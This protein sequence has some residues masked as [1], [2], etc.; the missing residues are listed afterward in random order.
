MSF[1]PNEKESTYL[2]R[3]AALQFAGSKEN[4]GTRHPIHFLQELSSEYEK[5]EHSDFDEN[6]D[7]IAMVEYYNCGDYETYDSVDELICSELCIDPDNKE[8][9]EK[10]N[11]KAQENNEIQFVSYSQASETNEIPGSDETIYDID[12]YLEAYG[13]NPDDIVFYKYVTAWE[14]K[15]ASFTHKGALEMEK[16]MSNH[17]FRP[18][19]T[20]A[21][22]TTDG[23]FPVLM[24]VLMK[25]GKALLDEETVGLSWVVRKEMTPD[26]IKEQYKET[27]DE[28]FCV[29][30]YDMS[31]PRQM[32]EDGKIHHATLS[33]F[34]SGK[35][36][37]WEEKAYPIAKLRV[38][39]KEGDT[40]KQGEWP[41]ECDA[42]CKALT[43]NVK[44]IALLNY[45]R[46]I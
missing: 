24:G 15:G 42:A 20:Y 40:E 34:A 45:M 1:V 36:H 37:R 28:E 3:L 9:I 5:L 19:R 11:R 26:Q 10:F 41:F 44:V 18:T 8:E 4:Y 2:K 39:L 32:S 33:V 27:P 7:D 21:Y 13:L 30:S 12:D 31:L 46:Y 35:M 16:D 14:T 22:T 29:A 17:I 25:L 6:L 23:D 38:T 43:D